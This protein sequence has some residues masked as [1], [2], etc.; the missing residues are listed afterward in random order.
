M[1]S[2]PLTEHG[3]PQARSETRSRVGEG[4]LPC[5]SVL[6]L[7]PNSWWMKH[8][9]AVLFQKGKIKKTSRSRK[10]CQ[11]AATFPLPYLA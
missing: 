2:W 5:S 9:T 4:R 10:E 1:A 8:L 6:T 11:E 3:Q 7:I